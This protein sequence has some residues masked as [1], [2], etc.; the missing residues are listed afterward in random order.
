MKN[1]KK[2]HF[3]YALATEPQLTLQEPGSQVLAKCLYCYQPL[4]SSDANF[5]QTCNKK[6]FGQL[7]TPLL[8]Y[9]SEQLSALADKII[10]SQMAVT[11]VQAK[12]SL[13]INRNDEKSTVKKLTIVGL[14]GDYILKPPSEYYAHLPEVE[15]LT[16]HLAEVCGLKT[17]PHSLVYLQDGTLCYLTKRVDRTKKGKL[18]MEDMCQLTERQTEDKY[19]GSHE[20]VAKTL[21]KYSANPLFDV[22]N[23]Y[24]L[25]VFSFLTGNADMHLKNFSLLE[26]AEGDYTLAPAY[27]LVATALVNIA[28]KEELALTLNGKKSKLNYNDFLTAFETSGLS[29]KV[30]DNTLEN[31]F[32]C[33]KE[34]EA[35]VKQ[36]FLTKEYQ[37]SF[38]TLLNKRYQQL[39]IKPSNYN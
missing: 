23:F 3:T 22:T 9:N 33:K 29:K 6:F 37:Q 5:H 36:S 38:L 18:H 28:D 10:H 4:E 21:L 24:E 27:D 19:K 20:Q 11:G 16:M 26:N 31:F 39:N 12:V 2:K 14:Y 34:M 1:Y 13:S 17:V 8:A 32:Y 7:Q 35:M 15:D 30:L 25:V